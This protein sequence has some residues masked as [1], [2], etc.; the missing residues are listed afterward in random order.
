[1][2]LLLALAALSLP[3]GTPATV[4]LAPQAKTPGERILL[5]DVVDA[6]DLRL[7][8]PALLGTDLGASPSAGYTRLLGREQVEKALPPGTLALAGASE[9]VVHPDTKTIPGAEILRAA[10]EW[11]RSNLPPE[12]DVQVE[13]VRDASEVVVPRG[14]RSLELS[15][16]FHGPPA[17]R[18]PVSLDVAVLVDGSAASVVPV[19]FF[20]RTFAESLVLLRE[21]RR[22]ESLAAED[23]ERRRVETTTLSASPARDPAL[24]LG[25]E[26][27]RPMR[28]GEVISPRDF[29][30]PLLV[31]RGDA[32]TLLFVRGALRASARGVARADGRLGEPVPV[33]NP[34]TRK[35]VT[36]RVE[37]E[38]LVLVEP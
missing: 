14:R 6:A 24:V 21:L 8:P 32:V 26:A 3:S 27:R 25:R 12:A 22:G 35:V 4:R 20:V 9:T 2:R 7:V 31:R 19:S 37:S 15:P 29:D 30:P 17:L 38:A 36:G 11:L 16:R 34:A 1:M 10:Q 28:E 13:V 23:F 5:V 18:G 33:E